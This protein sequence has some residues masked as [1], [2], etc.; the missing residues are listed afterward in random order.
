MKYG[1]SLVDLATELERQ[2]AT[3][4]DM[5]VPTPLM[6]HVTSE[7]GSSVLNIETGDGVRTFRTTENCRRQLAD[8]LKI[9]YAYFERMRAEQ[10]SLLDRNIDTWLHSQPE[11]RMVRTL[12]GNARAFLSDRYRRLDNYDLLAHVYPM[13]RE[14]PASLAA[15][16]I[17]PPVVGMPTRRIGPTRSPTLDG[18]CSTGGSM[19]SGNIRRAPATRVASHRPR[20]PPRCRPPPA[21]RTRPACEHVGP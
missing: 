1:R 4:Q 15:V 19:T 2:L 20:S 3:K 14:L 12:D 18:A 16:R 13:L 9:P 6:H 11:Q 17:F 8:R 10:P 7:S 21:R 5:I